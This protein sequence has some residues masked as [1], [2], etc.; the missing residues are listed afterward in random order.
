MTKGKPKSPVKPAS[1]EKMQMDNERLME[2]IQTQNF[3]SMDEIN[4]FLSNN[5]NGKRIDDVVPAKAAKQSNNQKVDD[6]MYEAYDSTPAKGKKLAKA[7]LKLDPEN[8]RALNFLAEQADSAESALK[9]FQQA[10]EF[11]KK[12]LGEAFFKENKGHFW[13]MMETRPYMTAKLGFAHCLEA[14]DWKE[15][16]IKEYSD[17]LE[18]NPNDNQG[19]RYALASILILTGKYKAF[20]DLFE[21]FKDEKSTFWLFNYALYLFATEGATAEA[22][23]A[24][25]RADR[26]NSNVIDIMTQQKEMTDNQDGSYSP[27]DENEAAY[28]LMDN[29][30]SW[31]NI[32]D[33]LEWL[34]SFVEMNR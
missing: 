7:A 18:L 26:E 31:M 9:F 17:L 27:G 6:M 8:V 3:G 4:D 29:F 13:L 32:D 19:V 16:A 2:F 11:G 12:Q 34:F 15:E 22:N 28:Y 33:T 21:K 23:I 10:A 5:V 20:S 24:L 1:R 25:V 30:R 14:L